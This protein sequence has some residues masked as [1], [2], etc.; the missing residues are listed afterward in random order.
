MTSVTGVLLAAGGSTR[1]GRPKQLLELEGVS[2]VRRAARALCDAGVSQCLVVCGAEGEAVA[3]E[4]ESLDAEA[5]FCEGWQAGLSA[6]I[7]CGVRAAADLSPEPSAVLLT[8][9]DQPEADA[10]LLERL[11]HAHTHEGRELV[12]TV[13]AG[14]LGAPALF[15]RPHFE[16]LGA[17][18]GDSGCKPV[19]LANREAVLEIS[20]PG[21]ER[22]LDTPEDWCAYEAGLKP[23]S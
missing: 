11:V 23:R 3:A 17:L 18:E 7:R 21:G 16:A 9:G 4:L 13:Y 2:L 19:L 8:L 1:M 15:G 5:V 20:F 22:D 6:S 14:T 10:A 12:A